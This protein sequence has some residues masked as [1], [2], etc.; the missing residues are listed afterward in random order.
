MD[1]DQTSSS[2][3]RRIDDNRG[4]DSGIDFKLALKGAF[5]V[6]AL[7]KRLFMA[8]CGIAFLFAVFDHF[9]YPSYTAKSYLFFESQNSNSS[10]RALIGSLEMLGKDFAGDEAEDHKYLLSLDSADFERKFDESLKSDPEFERIKD[11]IVRPRNL[12]VDLKMQVGKMIASVLP[13]PAKA[14]PV[15]YAVRPRKVVFLRKGVLEVQFASASKEA[16]V[17]LINHYL[18][19]AVRVFSEREASKIEGAKEYIQNKIQETL[20][21]MELTDREI[22][23]MSTSNSTLSLLSP[24]ASI[25]ERLLDFKSQIQRNELTQAQNLKVIESLKAKLANQEETGDAQDPLQSMFGIRKTIATLQSENE[26]LELKI[27]TLKTGLDQIIKAN[28]SLPKDEQALA[29]LKRNKGLDYFIFDNLIKTLLQVEVKGLSLLSRVYPLENATLD[30][31]TVTRGLLSEIF[32]TLI[33][34]LIF[35]GAV[36][37]GMD[38]INPVIRGKAGLEGLRVSYLGDVP[39]IADSYFEQKIGAS[40]LCNFRIES[41]ETVAFKHVRQRL[42]HLATHSGS[43]SRQVISFMS[44]G[45]SEGK[46]FIS[47]N[48][49]A[50]FSQMGVPCL[51]I[52]FDLRR[53]ALTKQLNL[54]SAP[55]MCKHLDTGLPLDEIIVKNI[56]PNLDFIPAGAWNTAITEHFSNEKFRD[57]M[58]QMK[59]KYKYIVIDTAPMV[60]A[61]ES[62]AIAQ[63]SDFAVFVATA[64]KTRKEY[65]MQ[66][67]EEIRNVRSAR[68]HVLLNRT[69]QI[70][71]NLVSNYYYMT[72]PSKRKRFIPKPILET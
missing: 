49:A 64:W 22:V 48:L 43:E 35:T 60:V 59:A 1:A 4:L 47:S 53:G 40:R 42:I 38:Y 41:K 26:L 5:D 34:T 29:D 20:K 71:D 70:D 57:V 12:I 58:E 55:G 63:D 56:M 31:V 11:K 9:A 17:F 8:L 24:Q 23:T 32:L 46:S 65:V 33:A 14:R 67:I 3:S 62:L 36:V 68:I 27:S 15:R 72:G 37:F 66:A 7:K 69:K 19:T 44:Y 21:K 39:L 50:C 52:D 54:L 13:K 28:R 2:E 25:S 18:N 61:H 45:N 16:T 51:L 10:L 30:R 6:L